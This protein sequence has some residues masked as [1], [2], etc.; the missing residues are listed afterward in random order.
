MLASERQLREGEERIRALYESVSAAVVVQ[1]EKGFIQINSASLKLF[2]AER[3]E[4]VLGRNPADFSPPRQ[5]NGEDSTSAAR[6]HMERA[7][8]NGAERFEWLARRLDGTELPVEITLTALELQGRP[9][10]QA[11]IIDLTERKRAEAELQNA[12]AKERE[13]SQLKSEFVSL[14]SHEF[15]TPLEII[16]SSADN[17][18]RYHDRLEVAKRQ[19]LLRTINKS[20]RRMSGMMEEVLVLGRF[21]SNRISFNPVW[22]DLRSLCQRVC[23]EIESATGSRCGILLHIEDSAAEAFGDESLLRHIFTNLLSNAVKYSE[24]EQSI[25][26]AISRENEAAVCRIT[27][28]GCGIPEGDQR[29][30]FQAFH[31]GSNVRQTPGTGLGL[32]IVKR[33]VDMHGG[34]IRFESVEGRG[35]TFTVTL[36]LFASA[37]SSNSTLARS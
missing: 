4:E 31:R 30:I 34:N 22:V 5:P 2:G 10:L 6:R 24:P 20:V 13:L 9:V 21:E 3:S 25:E 19:Q 35:T 36:P 37:L 7:K 15:R 32:L 28:R 29:R 14:V 16:M 1:D 27:D 12:L 11:V 26:F 23:D 17:L 33:C 18:D 8:T